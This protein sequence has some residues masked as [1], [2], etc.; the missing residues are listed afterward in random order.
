MESSYN[1]EH[2]MQHNMNSMLLQQQGSSIDQIVG[3][4][5]ETIQEK[6]FGGQNDEINDYVPEISINIKP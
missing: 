2:E 1:N 5:K 6:I 3:E 4:L